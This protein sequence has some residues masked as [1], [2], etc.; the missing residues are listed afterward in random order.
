MATL[1]DK[2]GGFSTVSKIVREFYR[3]ILQSPTLKPYFADAN[4]ERLIDHQTKFIAHVLG[5][6]ADYTGRELGVAHARLKI[7][8]EA[9]AEV[10]S[11]LQEVLEDAG[12]ESG[13]VSSVMAIV[14]GARGAV[15]VEA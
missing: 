10:A 3:Q 8:G 7:T 5:G 14:A 1:F 13:D 12:M 15:V 2:Y 9:F 4:M 6:P 11:I